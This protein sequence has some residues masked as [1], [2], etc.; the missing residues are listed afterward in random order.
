[1]GKRKMKKTS[2]FFALY[3]GLLIPMLG[4]KAQE[5]FDCDYNFREALYYL[6][7][8]E[9]SEE[10]ALK[11]TEYLTP[12]VEKG[13]DKAQLLMA[14]FYLR[15][16]SEREDKKAFN[17][18][19][20]SA[21]QGNAIAAGDL[22]ALYKYG[23][24]C[25]L[26]FTKAKQWFKKAAEAGNGKAI[27]SLG[28]LSLKGLGNI[29]QDYQQAIYWFEKS[30]YPMAKY[31]LGV[32]YR[33]GYGV[34]KD[35][36][37]ANQYLG[38][39]FEDQVIDTSS[40]ENTT[41]DSGITYQEIENNDDSNETVENITESD[42]FG[43]WS[44]VLLKYDWSGKYIEKKVPIVIN[45]KDEADGAFAG[46]I[47]T[48]GEQ[49]IEG[50]FNIIENA[51]DFD[52]L[53]FN[54]PH[55]SFLEK[56]PNKLSYEVIS[57]NLTKKTLGDIPVLVGNLDSFVQEFNEVGAPLK[58]VISKQQ[59]F[60]NTADEIS[61]DILEALAAQEESFIKLYPNPFVNDLI[62]SYSLE[63]PSKVEV[64][65]TDI[66]GE[67]ISILSQGENQLAGK[68]SYFFDGSHLKKGTYVV[69]VTVNNERKTRIIV[70]K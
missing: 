32:C 41:N 17:L 33:Y 27:Y 2:T 22:G 54:M 46:Y 67:K 12:C 49:E 62:I 60:A 36:S 13:D 51:I 59:Q 35:I 55:T 68:H 44:G 43:K 6:N 37:K 52:D 14:R 42:V 11:I 3:A 31:W 58:F 66:Y 15:K 34:E 38:T 30:N 21:E 57:G 20:K 26:N 45:F 23:K 56:I 25:D 47:V 53:S 39:N 5:Q 7:K 29:E 1:M 16:G 69:S 19:E 70:K 65:I 18:L 61:E 24:G 64:K 50:Y 63:N 4:I 48:I 10:N 28:Y 40:A 9:N 8:N